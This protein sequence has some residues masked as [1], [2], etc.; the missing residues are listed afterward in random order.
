YNAVEEAL[1]IQRKM[2]DTQGLISTLMHYARI[3]KQN[4]NYSEA[5]EKTNEA[6][7]LKEKLFQKQMADAVS[8]AE[9]KY[10]TDSIHQQKQIIELQN[11]QNKQALEISEQKR[12]KMWLFVLFTAISA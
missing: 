11:V 9:V 3:L 7:E 2:W 10:K 12:N 4:G 6:Y 8:D 1:K 5:L